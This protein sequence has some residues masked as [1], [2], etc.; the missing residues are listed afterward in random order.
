MSEG[1]TRSERAGKRCKALLATD[2]VLG[3]LRLKVEGVSLKTEGLSD[4]EASSKHQSKR[5]SKKSSKLS[6]QSNI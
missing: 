3:T 5:T 1:T 2:A 6:A 4:S